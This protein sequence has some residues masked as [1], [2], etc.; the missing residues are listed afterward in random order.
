MLI[1]S[2]CIMLIQ[3]NV[4][5]I[6]KISSTNN[7]QVTEIFGFEL[8]GTRDDGWIIEL[9]AYWLEGLSAGIGN[10]QASTGP[11]LMKNDKR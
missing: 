4:T 7:L 2:V 3:C 11:T 10:R 9:A 6:I 1:H 8:D 5:L